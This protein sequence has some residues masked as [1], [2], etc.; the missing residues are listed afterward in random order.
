MSSTHGLQLGLAPL[1][2]LPQQVGVQLLKQLLE[3]LLQQV[4]HQALARPHQQAK[5]LQLQR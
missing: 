2:Q 1:G 5:Q 3:Q 4:Q